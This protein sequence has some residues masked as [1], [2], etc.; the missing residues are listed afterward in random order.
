MQSCIV[1]AIVIVMQGQQIPT[2]PEPK[3]TPPPFRV[4][5]SASPTHA[6][7]PDVE[8]N[9]TEKADEDLGYLAVSKEL[10]RGPEGSVLKEF[11]KNRLKPTIMRRWEDVVPEE[12]KEH[13][14]PLVRM[15]KK[16]KTGTV[17]VSFT[18]HKGGAITDIVVD[19]SSGDRLLDEAA[20][21]AV[22]ASQPLPLPAAFTKDQLKIA[23]TFMYNPKHRPRG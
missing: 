21:K 7:R 2:A 4:P 22:K 8:K 19:D 14:S 17:R 1:L 23:A 16:G 6:P 12:A 3:A 15:I 10:L 11:L 9:K 13:R 20:M 18:V 5:A